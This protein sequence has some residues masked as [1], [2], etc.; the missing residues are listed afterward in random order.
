MYTFAT[1]THT[2]MCVC[3][4]VCARC[5]LTPTAAEKAKC[6]R[7]ASR[8]CRVVR[9]RESIG[10]GLHA[11][12]DARNDRALVSALLAFCRTDVYPV[13][14]RLFL[15]LSLRSVSSAPLSHSRFRSFSPLESTKRDEID[16]QIDRPRIIVKDS[17]P[18]APSIVSHAFYYDFA[19]T[20]LDTGKRRSTIPPCDT[21]AVGSACS[22][23]R[24]FFCIPIRRSAI[25]FSFTFLFPLSQQNRNIL[26]LTLLAT[27]SPLEFLRS[28][29]PHFFTSVRRDRNEKERDG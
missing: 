11:R 9:E 8:R 2:C 3:V 22:M 12:R 6:G 4:C 19:E 5:C 1:C 23:Y 16:R 13:A 17:S 10:C 28:T 25:R 27:F 20:P 14:L 26:S 24:A 18:G 29:R 15:R 21:S 7:R